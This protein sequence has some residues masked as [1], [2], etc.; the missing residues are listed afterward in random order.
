MRFVAPLDPET[1]THLHDL[2][3]T[4]PVS[5]VRHRAHAIL[6]SDQGY[7][8][9]HLAE[10]FFVDRETI[11]NWLNRWDEGGL[12]G[13]ENKPRRGRPRS[14]DRADEPKVLDFVRD[15]AYRLYTLCERK[16][17]AREALSYNGLIV[18][19]PQLEKLAK[20]EQHATPVQGE[21]GL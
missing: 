4:H 5:Q 18:A 14:I 16:Q 15:L 3:K 11:T 6:L 8:I 19:W 20:E 7:Q 17:H 12:T 2:M 13:L 21:L 1:K 9:N 10:I